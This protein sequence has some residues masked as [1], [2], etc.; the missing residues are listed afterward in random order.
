MEFTS[1]N[2][3][4]NE[5]IFQTET[6]TNQDLEKAIFQGEKDYSIWKKKTLQSRLKQV[7][8]IKD[9]LVLHKLK[10]AKTMV[11][12]IG[13]PITQAIAEIEKCINLC[14]Y[15]QS[16]SEKTLTPKTIDNPH[17]DLS[18]MHYQPL[19]GI[20]GVMP[21]N[22]PF[23]Q[24][25]RFAIPAVI[26]G[27]IIWLKH[28][29]NASL[30]NAILEEVFN[31]NLPIKIY[32]A[33]FVSIPQ[34]E[35]LVSHKHIQGTSLT[36]STR[37][38]GALASLSGKHIKKTLLELGG[39]DAFLVLQDA[40]L[41]MAIQKAIFSRMINSGQTCI[42]TKRLYVP[43]ELVSALKPILLNEITQYVQ[44]DLNE[45]TTKVGYMARADLTQNMHH[46][47][48]SVEKLNFEHWI[49]VGED[50]GNFVAPRVY[51]S[52]DLN[53]SVDVELFGPVLLVYAYDK[54]EEAIN[55]I[56]ASE[57][58]LGASIWSKNVN[59]A[60]AIGLDIEAGSIAINNIV[61]SNVYL[62]FGGIK[63]SGFGR[64]L[65]GE[66]LLEFVNKKVIYS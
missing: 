16:I 3:R 60:K 6:W 30:C 28:A 42:S 23:W 40:D 55:H 36:G 15:Y 27:N 50:D 19:G 49:K 44:S 46:Q 35:N 32:R 59:K 8:V 1:I 57:F 9:Q 34:I 51:F 33:T 61:Q 29:P 11:E 47:I 13:K 41:E 25:F 64:E 20:L 37:A 17:F 56:N 53:I 66:S 62:P 48:K 7:E 24:V 58:G 39:N 54:V 2:P 31:F 65:G 12:E 4:T 22:F 5:I 52:S 21:W 38:G 14:T 45:E 63:K 43:R 26:S 10:Y 18:E